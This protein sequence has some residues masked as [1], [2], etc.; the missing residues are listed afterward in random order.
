M[1]NGVILVIVPAVPEDVWHFAAPGSI[2]VNN[3]RVLSLG[4]PPP[5]HRILES[6][7]AGPIYVREPFFWDFLR[8][9]VRFLADASRD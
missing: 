4:D 9:V 1:D 2:I 5:K 7:G 6:G 3:I 8:S